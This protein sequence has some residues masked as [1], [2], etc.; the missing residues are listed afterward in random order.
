MYK[1]NKDNIGYVLMEPRSK[2]LIAVDVGDYE[3]SAK[4]IKELE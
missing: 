4:V 2:Q 3:Q 1:F